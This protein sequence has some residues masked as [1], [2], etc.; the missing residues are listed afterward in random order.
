[1]S[2]RIAVDAGHG[3]T[4]ALSQS[5]ERVI[6]PSLIALA[7]QGVDLGEFG[8]S[9]SAQIDGI[10]YLFGESAR[11]H[12][13]P[14]WSR[15]K[16]ADPDTL[17]LI[18][19][20]AAQLGAVGPVA[21]ATGL[22][23]SWFG[24]QRRAFK[25]ALTGFGGV[26]QRAGQPPQ[27]VWFESVKL[28]PQGVAAALTLL[29]APDREPGQYIVVDIGYRTTDFVA[30]SKSPAGLQFDP[31]EAGSLEIGTHAMGYALAKGL[32]HDYHVSFQVAEVESAARVWVEGQA[33]LLQERRADA[34]QAVAR[35]LVQALN[36]ALADRLKKAAGIIA[37]GGGASL[38]GR[39]IPH[40]VVPEEFQWANVL[41][42]LG[43]L[44][45]G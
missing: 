4:K 20:A 14:L 6:F 22:P 13:T 26:V 39:A 21:L 1:M 44:G 36:E 9:D 35:A 43:A 29:T 3:Y 7:P 12:A 30:V 34:T 42:Y 23:L 25:D 27:R 32:E 16:A 40:A 37:V 31:N 18:L 8:Q 45:A 10:S 28:L 38:L 5:G 41:A 2:P 15:D 19:V 33:V 11:T 24:S 17:R